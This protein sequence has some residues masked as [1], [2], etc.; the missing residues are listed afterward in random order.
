[1]LF[2]TDK[3]IQEEPDKKVMIIKEK[4]KYILKIKSIKFSNNI[5]Y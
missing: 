1:M 2:V 3:F 5:K 4:E